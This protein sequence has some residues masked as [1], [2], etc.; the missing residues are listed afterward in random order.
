MR[1]NL[2]VSSVLFLGIL[3]GLWATRNV[4]SS[5][6]TGT[7]SPSP[8]RV[9]PAE[10]ECETGLSLEHAEHLRDEL[11]RSYRAVQKHAQGAE[12]K[13]YIFA[14]RVYLSSWEKALA[15]GVPPSALQDLGAEAWMDN[16][17][18]TESGRESITNWPSFQVIGPGPF[19]HSSWYTNKVLSITETLRLYGH[20]SWEQE[21]TRMLGE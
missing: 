1:K 12:E 6:T 2:A 10:F 18:M 9:T 8:N 11:G 3:G 17:R 14:T 7:P 13:L 4:P 21:R 16:I 19:M 20:P 5:D 15:A